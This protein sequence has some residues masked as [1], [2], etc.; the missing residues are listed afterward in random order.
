MDYHSY[1]VCFSVVVPGSGLSSGAVA[2]IVVLLL[3]SAVVGAAGVF[4][5]CCRKSHTAVPQNVS[6]QMTKQGI[7]FTVHKRTVE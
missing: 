1:N 7:R 6:M 5:Y 3:V 4:Y 2:G